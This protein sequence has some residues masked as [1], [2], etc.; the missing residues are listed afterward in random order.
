ML[1]ND[2]CKPLGCL[3]YP[4]CIGHPD[5]K[6]RIFIDDVDCPMAHRVGTEFKTKSL[7]VLELLREQ[8]PDWW[9]DFNA[10]SL[11]WLYDYEKLGQLRDRQYISIEELDRCKIS[12]SE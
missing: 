3:L 12:T 8:L 2:N 10:Y 7:G 6:R 9:L 4:G 1:E 11:W 5:D